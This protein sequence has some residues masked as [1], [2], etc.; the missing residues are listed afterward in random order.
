MYDAICR[1]Y[2]SLCNALFVGQSITSSEKGTRKAGWGSFDFGLQVRDRGTGRG[3][4]VPIDRPTAGRQ[5][6]Q[7]VLGPS[8]SLLWPPKLWVGLTPMPWQLPPS[9]SIPPNSP[10]YYPPPRRCFASFPQVLV[11]SSI[12]S[13]YPFAIL[14]PHPAASDRLDL[15]LLEPPRPFWSCRWLAGRPT[16]PHISSSTLFLAAPHYLGMPR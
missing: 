9:L 1:A 11:S 5:G 16:H 10:P 2:C 8:P 6:L 7:V 12:S 15:Q 4:R 3:G 13:Q 14:I